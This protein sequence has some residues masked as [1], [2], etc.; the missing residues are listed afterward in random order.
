MGREDN[1]WYPTMRLFRQ[2]RLGDWD[3]LLA[4]VAAELRHVVEGDVD[5]LRPAA[6]DRGVLQHTARSSV[7][8][9]SD[10]TQAPTVVPPLPGGPISLEAPIAPG[11][12]FDRLSILQ[13]KLEQDRQPKR[14]S[15]MSARSMTAS[16]PSAAVRSGCPRSCCAWPKSFAV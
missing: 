14:S 2:T 8:K 6:D 11:E 13:I 16:N 10:T 15:R 7:G 4:R 9:P 3:E 5:R 12:L 1:P